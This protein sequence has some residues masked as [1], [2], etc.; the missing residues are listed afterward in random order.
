MTKVVVQNRTINKR[1]NDLKIK[2]NIAYAIKENKKD[3]SFKS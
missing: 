1:N 3:L 2:V